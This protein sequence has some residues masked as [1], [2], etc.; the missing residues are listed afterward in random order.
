MLARHPASLYMLLYVTCLRDKQLL[1][2]MWGCY[3]LGVMYHHIMFTMTKEIK[4][5]RLQKVS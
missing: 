3:R 5:L 1:V 2:N 4:V